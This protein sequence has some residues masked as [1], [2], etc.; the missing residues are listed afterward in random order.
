[1]GGFLAGPPP[2]K[3]RHVPQFATTGFDPPLSSLKFQ[4]RLYPA[5]ISLRFSLSFSF[6]AFQF[7]WLVPAVVAESGADQP[8]TMTKQE[9]TQAKLDAFTKE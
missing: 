2:L 9:Q 3:S 5:A 4:F 1:L 7:F 8:T 6:S